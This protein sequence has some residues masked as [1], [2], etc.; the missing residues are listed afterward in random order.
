[1][2]DQLFADLDTLVQKNPSCEGIGD[3][4][5]VAAAA[6]NTISALKA[7][8]EGLQKM[9]MELRAGARFQ[10]FFAILISDGDD[11]KPVCSTGPA[12]NDYGEAVACAKHIQKQPGQGPFSTILW[13]N[14]NRCFVGAASDHNPGT[15]VAILSR[16]AELGLV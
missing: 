2:K 1:M 8:N 12:F 16:I 5:H 9:V 6:R 3:V 7:Q 10:L 14:E 15:R 4:A 11:I 13:D